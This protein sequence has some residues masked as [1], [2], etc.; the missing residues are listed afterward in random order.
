MLKR[1]ALIASALV[2]LV[3][4]AGCCGLNCCWTNVIVNSLDLLRDV[5]AF[6]MAI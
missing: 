4:S 3:S 2:V 6:E 1:S 5:F